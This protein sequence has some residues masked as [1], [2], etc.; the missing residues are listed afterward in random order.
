MSMYC[1]GTTEDTTVHDN[2]SSY[3][4]DYFDFLRVGW[5]EKFA[6]FLNVDINYNSIYTQFMKG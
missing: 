2:C 6:C 4:S 1:R 5:T 3:N